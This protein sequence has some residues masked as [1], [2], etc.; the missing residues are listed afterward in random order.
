MDLSSPS[1]FLASFTIFSTSASESPLEASILILCSLPVALSFALTFNIPLASISKVTSTWGTPL[2][3]GGIPSKWNL[4]IVLLSTAISRSPCK[5]CISTVVWLSAAVENTWDFFVGIV[6]FLSIS[7]VDTLPNVSIPKDNGVTSNNK[8]SSTSPAKTPP[9]MAAPNA[10]T[11]S[12]L[13]L[14]FGSF[15]KI[16]FTFS[17]ILGI[18]VEPPTKTTSLIS[19]GERPA[20]LIAFTHGSIVLSTKSATNFSNFARVKVRFKCLGPEES[21]VINGKF[22]SVCFDVDNS[23]FAASLASLNRC[24]AIAS[25]FKSIP[26]L[27]LNS[28]AIQFIIFWSK[29]SPPKCVSPFVDLT[30]KTP[31]PNSK[32][33]ISKVP[34]PKSNTAIVSSFFLSRPYA[35]DAAVGSLMILLT[36]SPAI[37]PASFVACLWESLKYAGTV[38]TASVTVVPRCSS[39]VCFNFCKTIAP[40]SGGVYDLSPAF[41]SIEP[42]LF[43]L[44]LYGT[45]FIS[46]STSLNILPIKR[47]IEK[48]VFSGLVTACR[49]AAW[50]TNLSPSFAKPTIDGVVLPPSELLITVGS[51]PSRTA[52]HEF[53]VPKSIPMIFPIII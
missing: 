6:V 10:T 38:I 7:F 25:F 50:P 52:T 45:S 14:W 15:S 13:T 3:A 41:T 8:I 47:L 30:S 12:G 19:D 9:C 34:P 33:E 39:A 16:S 4:P 24:N 43:L 35:N 27:F 22:I 49:F 20:S 31:S 44:T 40:I 17:W 26:S 23:F 29:S 48:T 5:T 1:C 42:F 46:F 53:V 51:P 28:S 32:I 11:S 2:G 18:R 36:F 37:L 21:A